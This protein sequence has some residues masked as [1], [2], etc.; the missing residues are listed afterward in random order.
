[1]RRYGSRMRTRTWPLVLVATL[2][3]GLAV[4]TSPASAAASGP[5]PGRAMWVWD[6]PPVDEL[7][8]FASEQG[9]RELFVSAPNALA[10]S[11]DLGWYRQLRAATRDAGVRVQALGSETTWID[12]RKAALAWQ[13]SAL[14]TGLF[15]GVHYDVEPWIHPRWA[16]DRT[17]VARSYLALLDDLA[18]A[19]ALPVEVDL[20]FWLDEVKVNGQRLDVAAIARVDA[21]SVLTYR[22]RATGPDS[23]TALGAKALDAGARAG[24]PVRLSVETRYLGDD[25]VAA[26]QSFHGRTRTELERV[27]AE[28]DAAEASSASY[29]GMAVHD[30]TGWVDLAP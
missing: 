25:A 29:R 6:R 21:V 28:V 20:A 19:T 11:P 7:V 2:V 16:A 15:D 4:T 12:N 24:K 22:T 8:G 18:R 30:R 3:I 1:V 5:A 23:I 17:A 26:K 10:G 13:S 27:L 9:V 14:S